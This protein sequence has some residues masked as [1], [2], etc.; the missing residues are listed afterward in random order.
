MLD[1]MMSAPVGDDVFGQDPSIN[2]LEARVAD[3]F[4]KEAAL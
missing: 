1:A 4:G 2:A 3:M